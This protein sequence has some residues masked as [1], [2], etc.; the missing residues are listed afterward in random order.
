MCLIDFGL[1]VD[2]DDA[3]E[4][5]NGH[6][7]PLKK[8]QNLPINGRLKR[9]LK[10]QELETKH[11]GRKNFEFCGFRDPVLFV[12]HLS[13]NSVLIIDKPWMQVVKSFDTAPVHRHIFGT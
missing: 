13:K 10:G 11:N 9:K 2:R 6:D 3:S 1:P 8:P 7:P 4:I 12:G 5:V